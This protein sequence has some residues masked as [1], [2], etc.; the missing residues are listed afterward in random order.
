MTRRCKRL[1]TWV[2]IA[3]FQ[4][5][6]KAIASSACH[7]IF[8]LSIRKPAKQRLVRCRRILADYLVLP[9]SC[10]V[11]GCEAEDERNVLQAVCWEEVGLKFSWTGVED[12]T[13]HLALGQG[14]EGYRRSGKPDPSR[15]TLCW[16]TSY[17]SVK[18]SFR[19]WGTRKRKRINVWTLISFLICV[20]F[21]VPNHIP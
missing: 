13:T 12:L 19:I 7:D 15:D 4:S 1:N 2:F 20:C 14:E 17:Q 16:Q 18:K 21:S 8:L 10:M 3:F 6:E 11:T 5:R 9:P